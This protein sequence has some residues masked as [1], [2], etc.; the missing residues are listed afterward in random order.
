MEAVQAN[1]DRGYR[2]PYLSSTDAMHNV[3]MA[4][5]FLQLP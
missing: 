4:L 1:F 5:P 3:A 2:S